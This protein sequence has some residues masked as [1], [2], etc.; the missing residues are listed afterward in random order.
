[1]HQYSLHV[2]ITK[3][4]NNIL[5]PVNGFPL[6]LASIFAFSLYISMSVVYGSM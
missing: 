1:M 3:L 6:F 4:Y 5:T 2:D